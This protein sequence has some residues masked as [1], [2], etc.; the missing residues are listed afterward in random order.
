L[1][2]AHGVLD[3]LHIFDDGGLL[4]LFAL[5]ALHADSTLGFV[6]FAE[7]VLDFVEG[8]HHVAQ[9][10]FFLAEDLLERVGRGDFDGVF[11]FFLGF[12]GGNQAHAYGGDEE[13]CDFLHNV[14]FF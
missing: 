5:L 9:F 10:A 4:V 1:I 13:K 7:S 12:A 14:C 11:F 6:D 3:D 2:E 8:R